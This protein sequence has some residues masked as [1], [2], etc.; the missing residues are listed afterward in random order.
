MNRRLRVRLPDER[1]ITLAETLV[2]SLITVLV[3]MAAG[4]MYISTLQAQRTV[5]ELSESANSAQLVARSIDTGVRNAVIVK[6]IVSG[7]DGGQLLVVCSAGAD[8]ATPSYTWK[9]W[10]YSPDDEGEL[11]TRT[12]SSTAAPTAAP[13][14]AA[15]ASWTLLLA[16]VEPRGAGDTVFGIDTD[17]RV[18]IRFSSTGG[19]LDST[20]IDFASNPAPHPTYAPGSEPCT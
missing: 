4:G 8:P 5:G 18:S 14:S 6:P 13:S 10:Y 2:V 9:A 7:P 12:F 11:R 15:L 17:S 3:L 16:G 1:G 20:T 19:D